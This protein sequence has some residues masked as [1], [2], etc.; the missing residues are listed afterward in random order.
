[1]VALRY[2]SEICLQVGAGAATVYQNILYWCERNEANEVNY[3]E[4]KYW[5]YNSRVAFT[6]LFKC[7]SE[8]QV[9]SFLDKLVEANLVLVG[10][11]NKSKS[12]RTKW[13]AVNPAQPHVTEMSNGVTKMSNG[14]D[15][16]VQCHTDI[17]PNTKINNKKVNS[18]YQNQGAEY[19]KKQLA[20]RRIK[21][22]HNPNG[23]FA[24]QIAVYDKY[25]LLT[26]ITARA[27]R[28]G[29]LNEFK[30]CF[31]SVSYEYAAHDRPIDVAAI[32]KKV[33]GVMGFATRMD[34]V[35]QALT[36]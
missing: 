16:N 8:R 2:E 36:H 10:E 4:G 21:A 15:Q 30:F 31:N 26:N 33:C 32:D 35:E 24:R 7:F 34:E 22:K 5:T 25:C 11:F 9:R 12:D 17:K 20:D 1:M 6:R 28:L 18:T 19:Y 27:K 3:F 14:S 29:L 23:L 13:Y